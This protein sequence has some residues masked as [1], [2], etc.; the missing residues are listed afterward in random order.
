MLDAHVHTHKHMQYNDDEGKKERYL[1]YVSTLVE[2]SN[3]GRG[4]IC[5]MPD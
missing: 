5:L 3:W 1:T 4:E 2:T